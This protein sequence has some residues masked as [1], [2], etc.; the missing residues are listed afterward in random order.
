M[1]SPRAG[2]FSFMA[3][4]RGEAREQTTM[5][6]VTLDELI[7]ADHL[8]RVIEA[9]VKK[10]DMGELGFVRA[11]AAE[12]GRPGYDPRD[13][14]K[15][16]LY[17]YLH[18]VRSSR[19]LEAECQR[20]LEV[21]WLLGRLQ[22]DYKSIAEFRRMHR[23][24]VTKAGAQLVRLARQVGLVRGEWVAID[25]SKFRA[26]ASA[27]AVRER[28]AVK[29]YLDQLESA[30]QQDEVVIDHSAVAAALVK[31]Q[32]DPEPEAVF[33]R[34]A[35]GNQ[36][37]AYNVQTAV[38]AEHA[39][40]VAQQVTTEATD[41]RSLLPMAETAKAALEQAET[42]NVVADAG[43]SNGEQAARC[44]EQG[45]V[46]HVP[47]NRAINNQ[48]DGTLFDRSRF[49]Y[50]AKTD[51][52]RCPANHTLYRKQM[53]SRKKS[54]LYAAPV[55]V[56]AK[57]PLKAQCTSTTRRFVQR[58]IYDRALQRMNARATAEAMRLR[59]CT[60]ERPFALLKYV[61]FGHPRFLLRGVAGAQTEISLAALVYNLKTMV[62]VLGAAQLIA[63]LA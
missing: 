38:D 7:S 60:V 45:I 23:E 10:L 34:L 17:G 51:T 30:D 12:T 31:L 3:Y 11:E 28:E 32:N 4:I 62:N 13:L 2:A 61:I 39:I 22:P 48:G 6:P 36:A 37:P 47:A 18:Q 57:C 24:A 29:R 53:L 21:L 46:P 20:N 41:N 35:P 1:P 63:A 5:F 50:D 58:H 42:L 33:M 26:V 19:R 44:E 25:G 49:L 52:F 15:V 27:G 40:I 8:C 56:C 14:L 55:E 43:Y 16:Y 59:R 9:F 54:V